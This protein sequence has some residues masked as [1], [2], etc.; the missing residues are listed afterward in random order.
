MYSASWRVGLGSEIPV[1]S[2]LS[3]VEE[4]LSLSESS[5]EGLSRTPFA[6]SM[7]CFTARTWSASSLRRSSRICEGRRLVCVLE[8]WFWSLYVG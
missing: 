2:S 7:A 8:G 5:W 6:D 1:H 4:S 3:E